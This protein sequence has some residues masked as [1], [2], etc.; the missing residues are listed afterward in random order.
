M[1]CC[2]A[3]VSIFNNSYCA[4]AIVTHMRQKVDC[5][6][7]ATRN[8]HFVTHMRQKVDC[9]DSA[10]RNGHFKRAPMLMIKYFGK[11]TQF[12]D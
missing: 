5:R 4:I 6:D 2:F 10:T 8:G 3:V 12:P 11:E 1:A 7:S 9:R